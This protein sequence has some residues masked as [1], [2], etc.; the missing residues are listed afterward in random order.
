MIANQKDDGKVNIIF[1]VANAHGGKKENLVKLIEEYK[2]FNYNNKAIKFQPFKPDFIALPDYDWYN[3]YQELFFEKEI[4]REAIHSVKDAGGIWLDIF[5]IY[6]VEVFENNVS[7]IN[8][9]KL[10]ASVLENLEVISALSGAGINNKQLLINVSGYQLSDIERLVNQFNT[11]LCPKEIILQIG[12]QSYPTSI[13]D[14]GLQKIPVLK[15]AFPR[16]SICIADHSSA[17]LPAAIDIPVW[18]V[19]F[20]CSYIEKHFCINRNDTKYDKFSALESEE[21]INLLEKLQI[22]ES[23]SNGLFI[24]ESE[25][26]YLNKTYQIPILRHQLRKGSMVA[27]TDLLYRRT[28][29]SGMRCNEI[30]KLQSRGY[31]LSHPVEGGSALTESMYKEACVGVL[32]ACRMKSSRLKNKAIIPIHGIPAIERCLINCLQISSAS[33]VILTTS[34]LKE[35]EILRNYTLNGKVKFWQGDPNDVIK[36]YLGA[37]EYYGIDVIIRVTGDCPVVSKDIAEILLNSHFINGADY[38]AAKTVAVGS[39]VEIYN[40]EA[41]KR[42]IDYLGSAEYSEY[43]TWYMQNNP[44]FFKVNLVDLP[45]ELHRDYRLTLDY[46]EDLIMF[47]ELFTKLEEANLSPDISNVFNIID[48][49]SSI[50]KINEH[51]TLVYKTDTNLIEMLNKVTRITNHYKKEI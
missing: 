15:A 17:E 12:Y 43:M 29:Q 20:G 47:N 24:S 49:N 51:L 1:E 36:R 23:A 6:G 41:L 31:I 38:T 44:D 27:L 46:E 11:Q 22:F 25:K 8:G 10:Q 3:V 48:T 9:I 4:W 33:K 16:Y 19:G 50:G 34:D 32:V 2:K 28:G 45:T 13:S 14:T 18:A 39:S 7:H 30:K 40:M 21:I 35:D 26:D 5:D 37:C 42:V